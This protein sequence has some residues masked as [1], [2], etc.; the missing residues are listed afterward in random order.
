MESVQPIIIQLTLKQ[1]GFKLG[2]HL[3][4]VIFSIV[5]TKGTHYLQLVE[6][7]HAELGIWRDLV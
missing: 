1:P 7:E 5:N 6:S 2:I 3:H 4:A